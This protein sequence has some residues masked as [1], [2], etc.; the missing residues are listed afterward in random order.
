MKRLDDDLT[1]H[2]SAKK[3][4]SVKYTELKQKYVSFK[5]IT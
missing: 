5:S 2:K 4:S 3:K 1:I